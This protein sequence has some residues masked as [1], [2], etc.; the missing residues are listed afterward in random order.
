MDGATISNGTISQVQKKANAFDTALK[1]ASEK[2]LGKK[3]K[4]KHA[5]WVS[6]QTIELFNK[7]NNA[8]KRYK[9]TRQ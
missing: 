2:V 5:S 3:P 9:R 6:P 8:A 7:C 4:N 1:H